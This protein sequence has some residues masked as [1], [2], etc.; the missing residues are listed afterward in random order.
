MMRAWMVALALLASP[1]WAQD[2]ADSGPA[3][4]EALV[5]GVYTPRVLY[6]GALGRGAFANQLA[7][8]I[9]SATGVAFKGRGFTSR[10]ALTAQIKAGKVAFALVAAQHQAG[11]SY[12]GIAHGAKGGKTRLPMALVVGPG[13]KARDL[14]GLEGAKLANVPVGGGD[15]GFVANLLLQG[16]VGGDFFTTGREA[17]DVS[18]ALSLVKLGKADAAFTYAAATGGLRVVFRSR[19]VA[20]PAFVQTDAALPAAVVAKVRAAVGQVRI[21]GAVIDGLAPYDAAAVKAVAGQLGAPKRRRAQPVLAPV[22]TDAPPVSAFLAPLAP[23][24]VQFVPAAAS[25]GVPPPPADAF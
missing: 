18:G 23:A 13:S 3:V 10:G 19:P 25:L 5:I 9:A 4:P 16:E 2:G 15:A 17:R 22:A 20:L 21:P 7:Q 12:P 14:A 24:P 11:R 6:S 8:Q 1:A